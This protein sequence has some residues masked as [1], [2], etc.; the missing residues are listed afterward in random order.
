PV[1]EQVVAREL[2]VAESAFH[3]RGLPFLAHRHPA[4]VRATE[5]LA[6]LRA[7][8]GRGE[9]VERDQSVLFLLGVAPFD[10]ALAD[11]VAEREG[12]S[13]EVVEV[14][15]RDPGHAVLRDD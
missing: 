7:P 5:R 1:R 15:T 2:R 3:G 12:P 8:L 14:R 9:R 6:T 4:D 10:L 13:A 11:E